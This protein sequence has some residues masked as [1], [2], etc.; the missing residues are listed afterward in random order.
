MKT[1]F[2]FPNS[3]KKIGWILFVPSLLFSLYIVCF[4]DGY[5]FTFLDQKVFALYY[6][7]FLGKNSGFLK[8]MSNNIGD[9]IYV[10]GL[11][12]GGILIGFSRLKDEDEM[13]SKIRY[14]SLVWATYLNYGIIV[15][16]T[17]FVYGIGY[18]SIL[19]Y[20]SFTLILFF[21]IRFSLQNLSIK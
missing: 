15:L 8:I 10:I 9:E 13:I 19:M 16:L 1:H 14:E 20:N 12:L 5:T 21:I 4:D 6:D 11:I 7:D 3:F 17:L 2:L 18:Y